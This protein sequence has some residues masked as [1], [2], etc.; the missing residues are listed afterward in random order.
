VLPSTSG[1]PATRAPTA[2]APLA[3]IT[4]RIPEEPGGPASDVE[5]LPEIVLIGRGEFL[6]SGESTS[7]HGAPK[8][9]IPRDHRDILAGHLTLRDFDGDHYTVGGPP[10]NSTDED[11]EVMDDILERRAP[12]PSLREL[13]DFQTT[14]SDMFG[15][16]QRCYND[17]RDLVRIISTQERRRCDDLR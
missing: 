4:P 9:P 16:F 2:N 3:R 12:L 6:S 8:S 17:E 1:A 10:G 15:R 13:S 5:E 14:M 11:D 7:G